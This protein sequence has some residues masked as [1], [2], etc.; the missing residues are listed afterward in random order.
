LARSISREERA[1]GDQRHMIVQ[2]FHAKLS[3]HFFFELQA[4][5]ALRPKIGRS[6]SPFMC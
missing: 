5:A 4:N 1:A 2:I 6:A 3:G